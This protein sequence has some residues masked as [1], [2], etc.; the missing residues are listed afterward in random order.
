[1]KNVMIYARVSTLTQKDNDTIGSQIKR[2]HEYC[3][4]QGFRVMDTYKDEGKSGASEDRV[5]ALVK[6]LQEHADSIDAMVF[7][8]MDRVAR[9]TFLQLWLEKECKKLDIELISSEQ[10]LFNG[11]NNEPMAK[12]MREMMAVF[13]SL[14]KN[15]IAKR[16][17]NGRKHK[18]VE[19]GVKT[20]GQAP[21]GYRYEGKTTKTKKLVI[22]DAEAQTITMIFKTFVETGSTTKT[23]KVVN[24]AGFTTK[25]G[26][27]FSRQGIQTILQ[28]DFYIGVLRYKGEERKGSHQ[29]IISKH[30]FTKA[31]KRFK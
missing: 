13:A 8:Y 21:L 23:A 4:E 11:S 25:R 5:I 2:L 16:L 27:A 3:S 28:N 22:D 19:R 18:A 31:Q 9:D 12:A 6:Y 15:L 24:D 26:K 29:P 1:M 10:D 30:L 7:T 14:E 17:A 20:Q